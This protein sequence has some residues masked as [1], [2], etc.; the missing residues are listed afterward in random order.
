MSTTRMVPDVVATSTS[1]V[2]ES[3]KRGSTISQAVGGSFK[4][5]LAN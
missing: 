5:A 1:T 4:L 3:V 2:E